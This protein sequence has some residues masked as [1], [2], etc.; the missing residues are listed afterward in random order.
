MKHFKLYLFL[1]IFVIFSCSDQSE[2]EFQE[3]S[4]IDKRH[5]K[6]EL[7]SGFSPCESSGLTYYVDDCFEGTIYETSIQSAIQEYHDLGLLINFSE[8]GPEENPDIIFRCVDYEN[9]CW[10]GFTFPEGDATVI[11]LN[12]AAYYGS[13]CPGQEYPDA[14]QSTMIAIHEMGH[15]LGLGH[16]NDAEL[17]WIAG[18]LEFDPESIFNDAEAFD[19]C[20]LPCE[21]SEGDIEALGM[22]Y[23][24]AEYEIS[25]PDM[26]CE[27]DSA[28]YCLPAGL[29]GIWIKKGSPPPVIPT[30]CETYIF[31][32]PGIYTII[33]YIENCPV[34][35]T[36][37]VIPDEPCFLHSS[38]PVEFEAIC[39][40]ADPACFDYSY[41]ECIE[42]IEATSSHPKLDV[43]VNGLEICLR[44]IHPAPFTTTL[45]VTATNYCVTTSSQSYV[46][47]VNNPQICGN[48]GI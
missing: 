34:Q 38:P 48:D 16:T 32:N 20:N 36:I 46:L 29:N 9:L 10:S 37:E 22:L 12:T 30:N 14:C 23:G 3:E 47:S 35:K 15:A 43:Q 44:S 31:D 1:S 8:V 2:G 41:L 39:F 33:T 4:E 24:T 18:T 45:T 26:I 17:E 40:L 11:E 21:F 5:R 6:S 13:C 7:N 28:Q 27:D 42:E 25:G 19:L